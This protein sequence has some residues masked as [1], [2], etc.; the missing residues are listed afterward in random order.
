MGSIV[1]IAIYFRV[2]LRKDNF[3][4]DTTRLEQRCQQ[5]RLALE[6][7][8]DYSD[9]PGIN[10]KDYMKTRQNHP[11][12]EDCLNVSEVLEREIK[13]A[14]VER[15]HFL[16]SERGRARASRGGFKEAQ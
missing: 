8:E 12:L 3:F 2:I 7:W 9:T 5:L 16:S 11:T 10:I 4:I 1:T 13:H 6:N 14:P 15:L